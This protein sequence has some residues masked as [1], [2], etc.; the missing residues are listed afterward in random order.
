MNSK[1]NKTQWLIWS[2]LG[3]A[4]LGVGIY[5]LN[6][7]LREQELRTPTQSMADY[8]R[9]PEFH[10]TDQN[11][12]PYSSDNLKGH[13]WIA[14]LIFT[15]CPSTCPLMTARMA[16]LQKSI[17][18]TPSVHLVS[19]SVDPEHDTPEALRAYAKNYGADTS[20]WTFLTGPRSQLFPLAKEGFHLPVDSVGGDQSSPIVHSERFVIVDAAGHIR[21]YYNG[22]EEESHAKVLTAIGDLMRQEKK[23]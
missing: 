11:G 21:G 12:H 6:G 13:I 1:T 23:S 2:I 4:M 3:V 14:D 15:I 19:F 5:A 22:A 17:T 9:V 10:L 20:Q 18:K 16:A 8:G 7:W